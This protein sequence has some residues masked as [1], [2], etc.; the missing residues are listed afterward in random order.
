MEMR[1][2]T[3]YEPQEDKRGEMANA[4]LHDAEKLSG[5]IR[6]AV[7][8]KDVRK[9]AELASS[10]GNLQEGLG[11]VRK[12][13]EK[14]G[15]VLF[16]YDDFI[17]QRVAGK[18]HGP[19]AYQLRQDLKSRV[20][21]RMIVYARNHPGEL[22]NLANEKAPGFMTSFLNKAIHTAFLDQYK[23]IKRERALANR[24]EMH[25]EGINRSAITGETSHEKLPDFV[26]LKQELRANSK[27]DLEKAVGRLSPLEQSILSLY[28]EGR[29]AEEIRKT[30]GSPSVGAIAKRIERIKQRLREI[31]GGDYTQH[32]M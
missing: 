6:E 29:S 12:E 28:A 5:Q 23:Y 18:H 17:T 14:F 11:S 24:S 25:E 7:E 2:E 3:H 16:S 9:L 31:L 20:Y 13:F 32:G 19:D 4:I 27:I 30:T 21:E 22:G 1:E 26:D 10:F 8:A 15:E